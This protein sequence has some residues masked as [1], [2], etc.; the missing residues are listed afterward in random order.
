MTLIM[1]LVA[2][3]IPLGLLA[4]WLWMLI[5]CAT[6]ETAQDSQKIVWVLIIIFVPMIGAAI[7]YF[8]RKLPR[9]GQRRTGSD[10]PAA[11]RRPKSEYAN[12]IWLFIGIVVLVVILKSCM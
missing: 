2:A 7:Y 1:T 4:F 3:A 6:H 8:T 12:A 10:Q 9:D 11:A 5:D